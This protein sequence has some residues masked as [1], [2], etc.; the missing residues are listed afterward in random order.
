MRNRGNLRGAPREDD[1]AAAAQIRLQVNQIRDDIVKEFFD[2]IRCFTNVKSLQLKNVNLER[3]AMGDISVDFPHL[4]RFSIQ[5]CDHNCYAMLASATRLRFLEV[6]DGSSFLR[7]NAQTR[8]NNFEDFLLSQTSLRSLRMVNFVMP[9]FLSNDR[10]SEVQFKLTSLAFKSVN[11]ASHEYLNKFI[12]TQNELKSVEFQ[13][14]NERSVQHDRSNFFNGFLS[15]IT[16]PRKMQLNSITIDKVDYLMTNCDFLRSYQNPHVKRLVFQVTSDDRSSELFKVLLKI[17]TN[18]EVIEFKTVDHEES[19]SLCFDEG[20]VLPNCTS[21]NIINSSVR[22]LSNITAPNLAHFKFVPERSGGYIDDVFGGF[23]IRHR[24]IKTVVIGN[25]TRSYFFVSFILVKTIVDF[26]CNLEHVTIYNFNEVNKSV[27]LL[28]SLPKLRSLT[29]SSDDH[30]QF[31]AKTKVECARSNL[32]LISVN[33]GAVDPADG[34]NG[35][36]SLMALALR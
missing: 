6:Y 36:V 28:C 7:E 18:L 20:T 15:I 12:E 19:E 17:F 34:S 29:L 33:I 22:S 11:F 10:S 31:A 21:L 8:M 27:K 25:C 26:L 9:R 35:A 2:L 24:N 14:Y 16:N 23:F 3:S 1:A 4:T 32:K 13:M 5:E 30:Q